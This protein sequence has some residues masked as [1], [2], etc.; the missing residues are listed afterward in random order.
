LLLRVVLLVFVCFG[1]PIGIGFCCGNVWGRERDRDR[2]R[3]RKRYGWFYSWRCEVGVMIS[4]V[5]RE[6][7]S[8]T[9]GVPITDDFE[10]D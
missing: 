5:E 9:A 7:F 1:V 6:G 2:D 10:Q 4:I 8:Y 3:E